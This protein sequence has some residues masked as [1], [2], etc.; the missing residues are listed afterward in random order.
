[1]QIEYLEIDKVI[2]Y[3]NN[4][5]LNDG[6]AVDRVAASI[7]EYGFKSPIIVDKD[8]VI[9]AGHTRYKAAKKLELDTVPVIKADDLTP[10]QIRAYRIADNKTAEYATWDNDLLALELNE[11]QN[12][13]FDLEL[14]AFQEWEIDNLLNPVS[15]EDLQDFF[16]DREKKEKEPK[17]IQCPH[18][19]ESFEQ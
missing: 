17:K 16:G 4:P 7:K 2:P 18:C 14:T 8:N 12:L 9:V 13:D 3:V 1:M 19:G 10:E 5:R 11:L 6:E 15:D